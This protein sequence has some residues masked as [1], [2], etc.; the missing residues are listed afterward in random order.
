MSR[1]KGSM[2]R[3]VIRDQ[4]ATS[5]GVRTSTEQPL[6]FPLLDGF[7]PLRSDR[8]LPTW[9]TRRSALSVEAAPRSPCSSSITP[10]GCV[11][12][13]PDTCTQHESHEKGISAITCRNCWL[14]LQ[15]SRTNRPSTTAPTTSAPSSARRLAALW[16][17]AP[18]VK[19]SSINRTRR[20]S[21]GSVVRKP[22]S[23]A[24]R[25]VGGV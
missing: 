3:S 9:P 1:V 13:S 7:E 2:L 4:P 10:R 12:S 15:L 19:V 20:P 21:T 18:L 14:L 23:V 6:P 24:L 5:S 22:S 17:D 11:H 16:S 8:L 25:F